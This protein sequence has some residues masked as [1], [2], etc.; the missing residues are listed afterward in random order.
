[1]QLFEFTKNCQFQFLGRKRIRIKE[2][3]VL[4]ISKTSRTGGVF[5]KEPVENWWLYRQSSD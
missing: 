1:V 4:V 5:L 2:P 3:L